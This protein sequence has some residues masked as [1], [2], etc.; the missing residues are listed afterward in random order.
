MIMF[1]VNCIS[2]TSLIMACC[3]DCVE[4]VQYE[5]CAQFD[6]DCRDLVRG[7]SQGCPTVFSQRI[8]KIHMGN[9]R[10]YVAWSSERVLVKC[11]QRL[12]NIWIF[13]ILTYKCVA[14]YRIYQSKFY[15][16]AL[17]TD[18]IHLFNFEYLVFHDIDFYF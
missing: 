7:I 3:N 17:F 13:K 1:I 12:K 15:N 2:G 18:S 16:N 14:E 8:M 9:Y 11:Y 5:R 10:Y 6:D 4:S